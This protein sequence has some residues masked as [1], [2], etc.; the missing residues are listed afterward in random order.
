MLSMLS[1]SEVG[2]KRHADEASRECLQLL[3]N[4][5]AQ[6]AGF[7]QSMSTALIWEY[8]FEPT[9]FSELMDKGQVRRP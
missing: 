1:L 8:E 4:F 5:G 6:A 7:K 9:G 2:K 3:Q